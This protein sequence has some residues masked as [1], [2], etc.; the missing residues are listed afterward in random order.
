VKGTYILRRKHFSN[1]GNTMRRLKFIVVY[2]SFIVLFIG[3]LFSY[4]QINPAKTEEMVADEPPSESMRALQFL[5]AQRNYPDSVT[6][7]DGYT[8]AFEYSKKM[9][10]ASEYYQTRDTWECMGPENQGGRTIGLC[11]DPNNTNVVYAGAASGGLWRL[12]IDGSDYS[13]EY[14]ETGHPVLG[15]NSIAIDPT[16]SDVIY[17][18][19][20]EMYSYEGSFG[21]LYTRSTRGSVGIG[22]LKSTDRGKTW[23]KTID[24][25]YQQH[26]GVLCVKIHP[27]DPKIVFAGTSEGV[28]RTKDAG[29][30][31]EQVH[32]KLMA[33]D[34]AINP[35]DLDI[36]YVSCGNLSS[37]GRGIYRSKSGGDNGSWTKLSGGL[38][39]SW[40]GKTLLS[41]C[42][43]S[44]NTIYASVADAYDQIG[45]Y[46]TTDGGDTWTNRNSEDVC[47]YQGFFAHYV[48][49]NPENADEVMWAGVPFY[50]STNGGTSITSRSGMHVDHHCFAD[51]PTDPDIVYF[52]NDGGVY[53]T[54]NGGTSFNSFNTGYV[55]C[56]FYNGFACSHQTG[57]LAM[58][59]AVTAHSVQSILKM[60]TLCMVRPRI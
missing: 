26:R 16:N 8:K 37:D 3:F 2:L 60:M 33:V 27:S 19:T 40:G 6:S 42:K 12:T 39:S 29:T 54:T 24:W 53:R 4:Q 13:W 28:Y 55:T 21:G 5:S 7:K 58:A 36:M 48:R 11:V 59:L 43:S 1:G 49:V 57:N 18:G 41:L 34:L 14:I 20:G 10:K 15:V 46:R 52:G 51:D 32:D 9:V 30:N 22:L 50:T 31:W 25:A 35:S 45:L 56:Q 17:I 47:S 44:P 23:T 38:P